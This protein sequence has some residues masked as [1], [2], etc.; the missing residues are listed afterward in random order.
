M[1][2]LTTVSVQENRAQQGTNQ[3]GEIESCFGDLAHHVDDDQWPVFDEHSSLPAKN[4]PKTNEKSSSC[5][6]ILAEINTHG[7]DS[8]MQNSALRPPRMEGTHLG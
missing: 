5:T 3:E 4:V 8:T 2:L 7:S 1:C 6:P